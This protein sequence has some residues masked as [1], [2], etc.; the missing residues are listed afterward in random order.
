M[1]IR[2]AGKE[3]TIIIDLEPF[4]S[5]CPAIESWAPLWAAPQKSWYSF[6]LLFHTPAAAAG[7]GSWHCPPLPPPPPVGSRV[8]HLLCLVLWWEERE[9]VTDAT[10]GLEQVSALT[11][12]TEKVHKNT[13]LLF[14]SA[15]Q[16]TQLSSSAPC[17][18]SVMM[19]RRARYI[20]HSST[21]HSPP[22]QPPFL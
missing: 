15:L 4:L 10:S 12:E 7:V 17:D 5:S 8:L 19:S 18:V 21:C 13:P 22:A 6:S 9:G 16:T 20:L 1:I 14:S 11:T 2:V 3:Q